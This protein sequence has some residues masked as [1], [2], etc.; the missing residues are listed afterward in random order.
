MRFLVEID[1]VKTGRPLTVSEARAFIEEVI[2]PT[3]EAGERLAREGRIVAGGPAAGR[4]ALRF[5]AEVET[6][7]QLDQLVESLPLWAVAETRVTSL[8]GFGDRRAH[9]E[10]YL[11]RLTGA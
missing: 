2:F 11:E 6:P 5:I 1:H 4:V 10:S 9:I 3:L 7:Q 8:I